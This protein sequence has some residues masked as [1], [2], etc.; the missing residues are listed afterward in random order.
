MCVWWQVSALE[1]RCQKLEVEVQKLAQSWSEAAP[2][3]E[4]K[5]RFGLVY[6]ICSQQVKCTKLP[7][8]KRQKMRFRFTVASHCT[9]YWDNKSIQ[10]QS[11]LLLF[12]HDHA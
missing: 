5:V 11:S 3:E 6:R 10:A 7:C 4:I 12:L 2:A 1:Q 8:Q 9:Y